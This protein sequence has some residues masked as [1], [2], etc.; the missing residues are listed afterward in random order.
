MID[1]S[2]SIWI[3]PKYD[4]LKIDNYI[5]RVWKDGV[6]GL[7]DI[8]GKEL[9]KPKYKSIKINDNSSIGQ[10]WI[11]AQ[12]KNEKYGLKILGGDW[13]LKPE[14]ESIQMINSSF[15]M[16]YENGIKTGLWEAT[17]LAKKDGKYGLVKYSVDEF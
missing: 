11:I 15:Q 8:D 5:F 16:I 4:S 1:F 14:Y 3:E 2:G 7:L 12:V 6:V 13:L 17:Y 10:W 9:L